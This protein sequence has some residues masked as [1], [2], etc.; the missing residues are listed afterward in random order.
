MTSN[1]KKISAFLLSGIIVVGSVYIINKENYKEDS[2]V[3]TNI[4]I[5]DQEEMNYCY[6]VWIE[7]MKIAII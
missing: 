6:Q 7:M 3:E 2:N 1:L 4:N 5:N